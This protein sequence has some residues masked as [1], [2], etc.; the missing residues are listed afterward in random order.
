MNI[1]A[2]QKQIHWYGKQTRGYQSE[3]GQIRGMGLR[4]PNYYE[5]NKQQGYTVQQRER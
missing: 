3:E 2:K 5:Y 4:Q 1:H